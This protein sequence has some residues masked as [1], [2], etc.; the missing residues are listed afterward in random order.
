MNNRVAAV[1]ILLSS[2][3][4]DVNAKNNAGQTA[5]ERAADSGFHEIVSLLLN[6]KDIEINS[7]DG[8]GWTPLHSASSRGHY[9]AVKLLIN[10]PMIEINK[11]RVLGVFFF[12]GFIEQ[13]F[14]MLLIVVIQIF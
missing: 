11:R 13:L 14:M 9:E 1:R 5:L 10:H 3:D 4:I 8:L 7:A 12:Y 6:S 2:F